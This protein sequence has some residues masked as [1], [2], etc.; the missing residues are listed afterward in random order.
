MRKLFLLVMALIAL[1]AAPLL[2]APRLALGQP[3][4]DFSK[5]EIKV[6]GG[7]WQRL[8]A[9]RRGWKYCGVAWR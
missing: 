7:C 6:T 9:R 2:L 4:Q 1:G 5:V 8:H 3:P